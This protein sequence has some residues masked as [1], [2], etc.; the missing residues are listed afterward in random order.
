MAFSRLW[1]CIGTVSQ[2]TLIRFDQIRKALQLDDQK[3]P[4]EIWSGPGLALTEQDLQEYVL[5]QIKQIIFGDHDGEWN[6]DFAAA[7]ILP[8]ADLDP[9]TN[10]LLIGVKDGINRTFTTPD[11]FRNIGGRTIQVYHNGRRLVLGGV[12]PISGDFYVSESVPGTG[13][14]TVTLTT[15][16]PVNRSLLYA[17]YLAI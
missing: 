10:V 15:F 13:Y 14:D 7:G 4:A 12:S 6:S 9:R 3:D 1:Y 2:R 8:L 16:S 17:D 5:S 11:K